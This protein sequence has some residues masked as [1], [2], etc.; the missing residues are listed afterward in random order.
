[1]KQT[2]RGTLKTSTR[3]TG[4]EPRNQ[5]IQNIFYYIFLCCSNF[6][7]FI[8]S[9]L[10]NAGQK[11]KLVHFD[12]CQICS[13]AFSRIKNNQLS[14]LNICTGNCYR[15]IIVNVFRFRYLLN[16]L[17]MVKFFFQCWR[18]FESHVTLQYAY[19]LMLFV[20][21]NLLQSFLNISE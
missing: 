5:N 10:Q 1:M 14:R 12:Q 21:V 4:W 13:V 9:L 6:F 16:I 8:Y 15:N 3:H 19:Q 11:K 7:L 20:S 2:S 18:T 17:C